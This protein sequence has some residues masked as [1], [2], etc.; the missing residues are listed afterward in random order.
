MSTVA[1]NY[2]I[3]TTALIERLLTAIIT[4]GAHL[5]SKKWREAGAS[6]YS[7]SQ[8]FLDIWHS[9]EDN[10]L[11]RLKE[12]FT[13]EKTRICQTMGWRTSIREISQLLMG[14]LGQ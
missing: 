4:T 5:N 12:K 13:E 11:R 1:S 14:I 6:F 7:A 9:D 3:W 10:A 8:P 2:I